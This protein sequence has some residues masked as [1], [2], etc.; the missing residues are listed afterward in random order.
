MVKNKK[1][2]EKALLQIMEAERILTQE[3][4]EKHTTF[5]VGGPAQY[6]LTPTEEELAEVVRVCGEQ[7]VSYLVLGNGSNLLVSDRG[8][9]GAVI[10]IGKEMAQIRVEGN[11]IYA[12]AG[13]LLSKLSLIH[14]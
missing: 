4:M 1:N 5:R 2:F 7:K 8:I 3:P 6:Y 13:A 12:Q 10:E 9:E 14:I 11:R